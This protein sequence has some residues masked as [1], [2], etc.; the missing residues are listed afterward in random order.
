[1]YISNVRLQSWKNFAECD[2]NFRRRTFLVGPNA[3]GKSNF[4]D[5]LRFVHD[6][7]SSGGGL[8]SAVNTR[9]GVKKLRS[10]SARRKN[11]IELHFELSDDDSGEPIWT[12]TLG[13]RQEPSGVR[14]TV[15]TK[16]LVTNNGRTVLDRPNDPDRADRLRLTQTYLEQINANTDFREISEYFASMSYVHLIPQI[17]RQP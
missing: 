14:R 5:A 4:L 12:Y 6:I 11:E 13:F 1:M 3:S 2:H 17:I 10:L 9:G 16:E 7:A 15:V 8:D